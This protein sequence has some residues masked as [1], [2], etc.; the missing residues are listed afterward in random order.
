MTRTFWLGIVGWMYLG[1]VAAAVPARDMPLRFLE[2]CNRTCRFPWVNQEDYGYREWFQSSSFQFKETAFYLHE[3]GRVLSLRPNTY[4]TIHLPVAVEIE[5]VSILCSSNFVYEK[6]LKY[7]VE[8][9]EANETEITKT[10]LTF[11]APEWFPW[12]N[13]GDLN[14]DYVAK[15]FRIYGD[16]RSA[17]GLV[18]FE[19][20]KCRDRL[21]CIKIINGEALSNQHLMIAAITLHTKET[22]KERPL[23]MR[24]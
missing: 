22:E 5:G 23:V 12:K 21:D 16:D 4:V 24:R 11:N 20:Q 10:L 17:I 13:P 7:Y 18:G 6:P 2:L 9:S 19:R 8:L 3:K 14:K 1:I 15:K